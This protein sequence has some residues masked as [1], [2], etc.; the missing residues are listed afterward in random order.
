MKTKQDNRLIDHTGVVY[1]ENEI[2]LSW[3]IEAG[4]L[5]DEN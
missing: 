3:S 2:E 1:T 4:A 5:Y